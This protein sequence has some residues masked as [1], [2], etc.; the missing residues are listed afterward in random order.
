MKRVPFETTKHARLFESQEGAERFAARHE[1]W[2]RK[3]AARFARTLGELGFEAGRIL[4]V[5]SGSGHLAI[6]LAEALPR[7]EIDGLDRSEPMVA[8]AEAGI[9]EA[10]LAERIRFTQGDAQALPFGDDA[11][12]AVVSHDTLHCVPDPVAMLR[13]CERV[14]EPG[15]ALLIWNVRRTW[16]GALLE[17]VFKTAYTADEVEDIA[18]SAGLRPWRLR[19][20]L[21]YLDLEASPRTAP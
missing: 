4:D 11:F 18:R 6:A 14:L 1:T 9:A 15:G 17:S 12:D 5:G 16:L 3:A 2:A 8:I 7:A 13:E 10:G 21:L 20:S 19:T